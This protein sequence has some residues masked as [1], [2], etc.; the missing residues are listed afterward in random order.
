MKRQLV[1][2]DWAMK[3]LLRQEA[4]FVILEGL[5]SALL[6]RNV[7]VIK[8]LKSDY[9]DDKPSDE[10]ARLNLLASMQTERRSS[11]IY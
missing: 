11:F 5:L 6:P 10:F 1:R 4:N 7:K 9:H 8:L 3:K 2:F